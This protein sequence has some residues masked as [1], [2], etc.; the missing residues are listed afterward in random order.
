MRY[1]IYHK[2][3]CVDKWLKDEKLKSL[4]K[5]E[6]L[7][8]CQN[9]LDAD[10]FEYSI[11]NNDLLQHLLEK[12]QYLAVKRGDFELVVEEAFK[13]LDWDAIPDSHKGRLGEL[14]FL[15][16]GM[17]EN[18]NLGSNFTDTDITEDVEYPTGTGLRDVAIPS[19]VKEDGIPHGFSKVYLEGAVHDHDARTGVMIE[20]M[21]DVERIEQKEEK[22]A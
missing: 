9:K 21:K 11:I 5:D 17:I 10:G 1:T 12:L 7:A 15:C 14:H 19:L 6:I 22:V 8:S 2:T 18:A 4:N 3:E 13:N 20:A 16:N